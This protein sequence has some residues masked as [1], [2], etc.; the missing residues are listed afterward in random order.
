MAPPFGPLRYLYVGSSDVGRDLEFYR[1]RLGAEI[2]WD[3]RE[4]GAHVAA[5]RFGTGP[6]LLLADHRPARSVIYVFDVAD[7]DA[8][9]KRLEARG[10]KAPGEPFELPDGPCLTFRDPSGNELGLLQPDRPDVLTHEFARQ[11]GGP[12]R[13]QR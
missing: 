1:D 9:R 5:V 8:A 10:W 4:S 7:L 2:V 13:K 6:L 12:A 3:F 11:R